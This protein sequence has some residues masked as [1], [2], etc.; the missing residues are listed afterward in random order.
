MAN[1][2]T[3]EQLI[4]A[5]FDGKQLH[6]ETISVQVSGA[7]LSGAWSFEPDNTDVYTNLLESR[8]VFSVDA[9]TSKFLKK[10]PNLVFPEFESLILEGKE[11]AN[12]MLETFISYVEAEKKRKTLVQPRLSMWPE[13]FSLDKASDHL[14]E[15]AGQQLPTNT[16]IEFKPTLAAA[17]VVKKYVDAWISDESERVSRSYL[18]IEPNFVRLLPEAWGSSNG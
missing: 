1:P 12:R 15:I 2:H 11:N 8:L 4:I 16:P 5:H 13:T 6:L 9:E 18:D 17:M 7:V 3:L 10:I 14:I